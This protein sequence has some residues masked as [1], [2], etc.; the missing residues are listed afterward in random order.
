MKTNAKITLYGIEYTIE[1]VPV[2]RYNSNLDVPPSVF[3][4]GVAKVLRGLLKKL[5]SDGVLKYEKVWVQSETFAGG[6]AIDVYVDGADPESFKEIADITKVFQAGT[7][8][9]M[10]DMYEYDKDRNNVLVYDD[11]PEQI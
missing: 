7:F 10:I 2:V 4:A 6:D 9:G 11:L 5:R 8:N 1:N 3:T